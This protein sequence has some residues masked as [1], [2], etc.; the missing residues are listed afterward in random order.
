M[1]KL[2]IVEGLPGTGKSTT[3]N[4]IADKVTKTGRNVVCIDEGIPN[5]PADYDNYDFPDFETERKRILE[6][7]SEFVKKASK[8]TIYIFNCIFL[9]NPMS[10]TMMRFNLDVEISRTYIREIE[11]II[12]PMEPVIIYISGKDVKGTVDRVIDER[13]EDWLNAVIDYHVNQEY[14]RKKELFGYDGYIEC[15]IE[16]K[17][18]EMDILDSLSLNKYIISTDSM[19]E[20]CYKYFDEQLDTVLQKSVS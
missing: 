10:E 2:I 20:E 4:M 17:K 1:T 18:R 11:E 12:K 19:N 5:H 6:K 14:G 15:L 8:D 16:R 7:W 13:R 3:A 9:Q